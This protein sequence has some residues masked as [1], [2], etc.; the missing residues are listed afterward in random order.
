MVS[1][2]D[3]DNFFKTFVTLLDKY[4]PLKQEYLRANHANFLTKQLKKTVIKRLE[5][6]MI[7]SKIGMIIPKVLMENNATQLIWNPFAK[8]KKTISRI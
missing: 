2:I 6:V 1:K 3:Y 7:F 4:V 8:S 5:Y